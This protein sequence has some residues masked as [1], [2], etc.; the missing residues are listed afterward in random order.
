M[1]SMSFSHTNLLP[2]Q[3]EVYYFPSILTTQQCQYYLDALTHR[4]FWQPDNIVMFGR[5]IVTKRHVAWYGDD[6]ITYRYAGHLKTARPWTD[7]L[8]TLKNIVQQHYPSVYNSCLLNLYHHGK[9][10]MGWHQDNEP[11][12]IQQSPIA[13]LSF[14][15]T[16]AMQFRHRNTFERIACVLE[17]GSLLIMQG[18]CQQ[19]W[20]HRIPVDARVDSPRINITFRHLHANG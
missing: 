7:A 19:H 6:R 8:R 3:G 18:A 13:S 20:Q 1:S 12:I 4:I 16:R 17:P 5:T 15:A 2:Y 14:G 11:E 10:G 9:E